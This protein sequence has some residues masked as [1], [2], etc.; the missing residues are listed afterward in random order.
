MDAAGWYK[1]D[2]FR[3]WAWNVH[4]EEVRVIDHAR[5]F[6][7][8]GKGRYELCM[9]FTLLKLPRCFPVLNIVW[10]DYMEGP[11]GMRD[12]SYIALNDRD[13]VHTYQGVTNVRSLARCSS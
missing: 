4:H 7:R 13:G 2:S 9:T 6:R 11:A 1:S 3:Q 12:E 10:V 5:I 8:D